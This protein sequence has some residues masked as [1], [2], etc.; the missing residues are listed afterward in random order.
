VAEG[1]SALH[2][3]AC[4]LLD[5]LTIALGIDLFPVLDSN[6]DWSTLGSFTLGDL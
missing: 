5:N 3:A 6:W 2:A 1:N 4:L